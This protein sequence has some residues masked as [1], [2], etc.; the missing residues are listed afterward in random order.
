[1]SHF[2]LI[3]PL[4]YSINYTQHAYR[5]DNQSLRNCLLDSTNNFCMY[6]YDLIKIPGRS[7]DGHLDHTIEQVTY[8]GNAK[9]PLNCK[10]NIAIVSK[11]FNLI[12]KKLETKRLESFSEDFKCPHGY[13]C[14]ERCDLLEQK[15]SKY[16]RIQGILL[17]PNPNYGLAED[18]LVFDLKDLTF[19][20]NPKYHNKLIRLEK[21]ILRLDLNSCKELRDRLMLICKSLKNNDNIKEFIKNNLEYNYYFHLVEKKLLEFFLTLDIK[22]IL[23]YCE[24]IL[25]N[26]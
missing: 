23:F 9:N 17:M 3:M 6:R 19:K 7:D 1:M 14:S 24:I 8:N 18:A 26:K 21:H 4:N 15:L 22:K 10:Y 11:D 12:T 16:S 13:I 5:S 25:S 20:Q 2:T